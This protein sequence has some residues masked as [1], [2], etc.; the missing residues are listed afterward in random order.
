MRRRAGPSSADHQTVL[1]FVLHW[2][3]G[4]RI[5]TAPLAPGYDRLGAWLDEPAVREVML[6]A[7]TKPLPGSA[8][9]ML[10]ELQG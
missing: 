2:S 3:R 5:S 7:R 9:A 8:Q 4:S 6:T 1:G 10:F